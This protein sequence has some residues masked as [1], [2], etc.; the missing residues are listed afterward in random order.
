[1]IAEPFAVGTVQYTV[2]DAF[3]GTALAMD[4]AVGTSVLDV[5]NEG[6]DSAAARAPRAVGAIVD[7]RASATTD[8]ARHRKVGVRLDLGLRVNVVTDPTLVVQRS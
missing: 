5:T 8:R 1:V 6:A 7:S 3:P 4:G 2:A